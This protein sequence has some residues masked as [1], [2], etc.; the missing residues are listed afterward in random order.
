[1][2]EVKKSTLTIDI[3]GG[4]ATGKSSIALAIKKTLLCVGIIATIE[5]D[6]D[7]HP[8]TLESDWQERLKSVPS[9]GIKIRTIRDLSTR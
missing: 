2:K 8:G 9:F 4:P 7:E 3:T 5:G 1:M 6:E